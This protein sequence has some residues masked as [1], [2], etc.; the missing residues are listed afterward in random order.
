MAAGQGR[1]RHVVDTKGVTGAKTGPDSDARPR[2]RSK[3]GMLREGRIVRRGGYGPG[4]FNDKRP[5]AFG[6]RR[7]RRH[8]TDPDGQ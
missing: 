5:I 3:K 8:V 6:I 1:H 4:F 7:R 2:E